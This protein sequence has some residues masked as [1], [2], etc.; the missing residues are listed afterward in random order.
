MLRARAWLVRGVGVVALAAAPLVFAP[1]SAHASTF[2]VSNTNDSGAGSLRQAF[3][4]ASASGGE[5]DVASGL[6]TITLTGGPISYVAGGDI[7]VVGNG[8]TVD[9]DGGNGVIHKTG[10]TGALSIDGMTITGA[11]ASGG[12]VVGALTVQGAGAVTL[13]DCV[14]TGNHVT[15]GTD[16]ADVGAVVLSSGSAETLTVTNCQITNNVLQ[17]AA[18]A[19][20]GAIDWDADGASATITGSVITGNSAAAGSNGVIAGGIDSEGG[21]LTITQSFIGNNTATGGEGDIS[22]GVVN[23]GGDMTLSYSSIT[24]NTATGQIGSNF[25]GAVNNEGGTQTVTNSTIS[26]NSA[27][28]AVAPTS[29]NGTGTVGTHERTIHGSSV[30]TS[31][32]GAW[33][34]FGG[35]GSLVYV[36][37]DGN[38]GDTSANFNAANLIQQGGV[39]SFFG[40]AIG[41]PHNG[42]NCDVEGETVSNV[43][44]GFNAEDDAGATCKFSSSTQDTVGQP[45]SLSALADNGGPG[46]TQLPQT[47]S[48]LVDAIP[49]ASC[50]ADGAA[51]ITTDERGITRPQGAGCE[52][53]AVELEVVVPAPPAPAPAVVIQPA[54]T[55]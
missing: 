22:G 19:D 10:G 12:K 28:I 13:S 33:L 42:P 3:I 25:G 47:T 51:G 55:G 40:T 37:M 48:V 31:L 18:D 54:F 44:H 34:N 1:S 8:V 39:V 23:E 29:A 46:P 20:I 9:G 30:S 38:T 21:P 11:D 14:V 16:L 53:G 43:S 2:T 4:D 32:A 5:I 49:P 41:D 27:S 17:G 15:T 35:G 52:I 50:Q 36:T 24:D 26:G 7:S 45:L 6:G